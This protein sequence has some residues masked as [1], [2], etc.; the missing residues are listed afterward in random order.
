MR[1]F[2]E[3]AQKTCR[4]YSLHQ[5]GRAERDTGDTHK[6]RPQICPNGPRE[7]ASPG[8]SARGHRL[9]QGHRPHPRSLWTRATFN[10]ISDCL[11]ERKKHTG[12]ETNKNNVPHFLSAMP[13]T[14]LSL[15]SV[16]VWG[17]PA[18]LPL[19]W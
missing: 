14:Y 2:T 13:C 11:R 9:Q 10:D 19:T 18:L 12:P 5:E 8:H 7:S 3:I 17:L 16:S 6:T 1:E 15:T 4:G